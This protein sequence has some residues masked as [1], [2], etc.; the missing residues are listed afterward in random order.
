ML[1]LVWFFSYF[2]YV[3]RFF[4]IGFNENES[5]IGTQFFYAAPSLFDVLKEVWKILGPYALLQKHTSEITEED[6]ELTNEILNFYV[7]PIEEIGFQHF[8]NFTKMM[9]DSF[10]WFGVH[11]FLDLHLEQSTRN[12]YFYRNKY[13]VWAL[14]SKKNINPTFSR[15]NFTMWMLL[16]LSTFLELPMLMSCTCSG[17]TWTMLTGLLTEKMQKSPWAWPQCE[18]TLSSMET[19]LQMIRTSASSGIRPLLKKRST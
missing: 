9:T 14:P 2:I 3:H 13:Y 4:I 5:L 11:R 16:G 10:F 18:Q 15:E 1:W 6:I 8:D 17:I 19:Q 12:T 7:G